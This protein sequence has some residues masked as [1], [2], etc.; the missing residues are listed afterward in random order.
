MSRNAALAA[1]LASTIA[2]AACSSALGPAKRLKPVVTQ[3]SAFQTLTVIGSPRQARD[4]LSKAQARYQIDSA[5]VQDA[6]LSV[7]ASLDV[8]RLSGKVRGAALGMLTQSR[9]PS[10]YITAIVNACPDIELV[11]SSGR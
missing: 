11:S 4:A 6:A 9:D 1:A 8:N 3:Y 10:R 2:L 7:V 5:Q